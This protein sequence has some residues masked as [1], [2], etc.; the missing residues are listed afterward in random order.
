MEGPPKSKQGKNKCK[1]EEFRFRKS[2]VTWKTI[3]ELGVRDC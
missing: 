2:I 1:K 3:E